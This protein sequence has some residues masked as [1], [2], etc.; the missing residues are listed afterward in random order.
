MLLIFINYLYH[1]ANYSPFKYIIICDLVI[2]MLKLSFKINKFFS[3]KIL[4]RNL[5]YHIMLYNNI[6]N[7]YN[8]VNKILIKNSKIFIVLHI[9]R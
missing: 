8:F 4:K 2:S 3:I 1:K 6:C 7:D 9:G 5:V